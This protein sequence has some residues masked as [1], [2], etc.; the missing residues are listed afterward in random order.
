MTVAPLP[1]STEGQGDRKL[2]QFKLRFNVVSSFSFRRRQKIERYT[3]PDPTRR[4]AAVD[5]WITIVSALAASLGL[6]LAAGL[7]YFDSKV[8]A[9]IPFSAD[10]WH[11][12]FMVP[13]SGCRHEEVAG[14]DCPANPNESKLWESAIRRDSPEFARRFRTN[15]GDTFWLGIRIPKEKLR[16]AAEKYA[17]ALILPRL[18]G[19]VQVWFDGVHQA[20]H[21]FQ[22]ERLPLRLSLSAMRLLEDR[23]LL[24]VIRVHPYPHHTMPE[25]KAA[26]R[27][28]G[29]FTPQDADQFERSIVFAST[30]RHLIALALFLLIAGFMWSVSTAS[31]TRDY[32]VGTQLALLI[33]SI[34]L[35]SVDLS[36]RVFN[37]A[38]F[39]SVFFTL[40]VLEGLFVARL[41]WTVLRGSRESSILEGGLLLATTFL[42][43][44][45]VPPHW[46]E[47]VGAGVMTSAAL[48]LVYLICAIAVGARLVRMLTR[49]H[50][51]SRTRIEFL[52]VSAVSMSATGVAYFIESSQNSGFNVSWSRWI[53]FVILFGLVRVFTKS[54]KTKGSLIELAPASRYHKME[55]PPAR[56]EGWLLHLD[57]LKFSTDTQV[58]STILSHLWTITQLNDGV[59][60]RA[61][62][63][64]LTAV[65]EKRPDGSESLDLIHALSEMAKCL[66]DLEER[67]P[68]VF[69]DRSYETSILF[70][71]AALRG[72]IVPTWQQGETGLSRLPI[73]KEA[74]GS[75][76]FAAVQLLLATDLD[77][78]LRSNDASI[79]VFDADEANG[80]STELEIPARAR[81]DLEDG[82][83]VVAFVASR[84]FSRASSSNKSRTQRKAV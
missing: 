83:G 28:E 3:L 45:C 44:V 60:V 72:A 46:I 51:A 32:A 29:F 54:N 48:P 77:A 66:K 49:P 63:R 7:L 50:F 6:V 21:D 76:S 57:I 11:V 70:R 53:N 8:Q 5:L 59:V 42:V 71:A 23:D 39:Q 47:S 55:T 74:E 20:T 34:S 78:A 35:V 84:L 2:F 61:E 69:A 27:T 31:R 68:I 41:T 4:R 22:T 19:N 73:W 65:F 16:L 26:D 43:F 24:V 13:Q 37:V 10:E 15:H 62:N 67:L 58:M 25:S 14:G 80:L 82:E 64:S 33:A 56:V 9:R 17:T 30:S 12:S 52:I 38:N 79:V 40:L 1:I 75:P 18:N 81:V 36:L